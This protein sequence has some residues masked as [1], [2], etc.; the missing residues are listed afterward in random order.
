LE[1]LIDNLCK[2]LKLHHVQRLKAGACSISTG[3]VFND[4]LNDY[5]RIADHCS[6]IAVAMIALESDSF[7]THA[8]LDSVKQLKNQ[9]YAKYFDAFSRKYVIE[10]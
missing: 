6:N 4:I 7:D 8:Y 5:E 10:N 9:T 3:F 2:E 1:E